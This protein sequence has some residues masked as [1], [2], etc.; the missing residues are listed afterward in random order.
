MILFF[1]D[2]LI[3]TMCHVK[4]KHWKYGDYADID[5]CRNLLP[6]I[7]IFFHCES[8]ENLCYRIWF[9]HSC[10]VEPAYWKNG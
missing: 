6:E 3:I 7:K 1:C 8:V 4:I 9:L 10:L 5:L 2:K